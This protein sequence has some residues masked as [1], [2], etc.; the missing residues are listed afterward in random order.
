MGTY[1]IN[2][3]QAT[4]LASQ[5]IGGATGMALQA[6]N[7]K[8]Q[9]KGQKQIMEEQAKHSK[10]LADYQQIKQMEMWKN[11]NYGAQ[12]KEMKEAG[13]SPGLI[14]GMSG[15]GGISTGGGM[16]TGVSGGS[17][18]ASSGMGMGMQ[19][20]MNIMQAKVMESQANLNN[21]QA[22]K[23]S[24]AETKKIGAEIEN[25][26]TNTENQKANTRLTKLN[27]DMQ[28]MQNYI[29]NNTLDESVDE[30]IYKS[31]IAGETLEEMER[32]NEIGNKTKE[33]EIK[34]VHRNYLNLIIEAGL[35]EAQKKETEAGTIKTGAETIAIDSERRMN[36][37]RSIGGL[38]I[39]WAEVAGKPNAKKE[40]ENSDEYKE[41]MGVMGTL[42]TQ[43]VMRYIFKIPAPTIK[44]FKFW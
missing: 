25:L 20:G 6:R 24:G 33:D 2:S 40:I 26:N 30:A 38:L 17:I 14:Y 27:A 23:I 19:M 15:G 34:T 9:V 39:K 36:I 21:A 5:V 10:E 16:N 35:M 3:D 7:I 32:K 28:E 41:I 4:A 11:T 42:G 37:Q 29:Q 31:R 22:E 43:A 8:Q 13:L 1:G 18:D 44:G 12:I